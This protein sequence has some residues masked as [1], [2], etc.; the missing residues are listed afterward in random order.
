MEHTEGPLLILAGAGAEN[1]GDHPPDG[2]S[3]AAHKV[4]PW[5][6]L[7][8]TTNALEAGEMRDRVRG[9]GSG[10]PS[11]LADR[12]DFPLVLRA[13]APS[14]GGS[15]CRAPARFHDAFHHLR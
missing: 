1:Q 6:I 9:V 3:I 2:L 13:D 8:A 10:R 7:A 15:T 12:L 4:P 14:G 5:A 11:G